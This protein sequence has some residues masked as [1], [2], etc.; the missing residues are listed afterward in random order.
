[1][2]NKRNKGRKN[3]GTRQGTGQLVTPPKDTLSSWATLRPN[4]PSVMGQ[5]SAWAVEVP[6]TLTNLTTTADIQSWSTCKRFKFHNVKVTVNLPGGFDCQFFIGWNKTPL[7]GTVTSVETVV[8]YHAFL[9]KCDRSVT[10]RQNGQVTLSLSMRT[11]GWKQ[12]FSAALYQ[13][14][15]DLL[16]REV[17]EFCHGSLIL[18]Y[19]GAKTQEVQDFIKGIRI[20]CVQT[21]MIAKVA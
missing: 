19:C 13:K 7:T 9:D 16:D 20:D 4:I 10:S 17:K 18:G 2:A 12:Y 5:K 1:M 15:R 6:F 21:L 14:Y 3:K 11:T 8:G